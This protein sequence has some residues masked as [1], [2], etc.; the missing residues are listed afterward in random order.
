M[1]KHLKTQL[2]Q[3]YRDIMSQK[4]ALEKQ[5]LE[6][7]LSLASIAPDEMAF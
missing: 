5:I 6:N 2:T 3:F 1:E 4:Y 7:A